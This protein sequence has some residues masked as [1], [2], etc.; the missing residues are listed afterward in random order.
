MID[1]APAGVRAPRPRRR[2]AARP[3]RAPG[4]SSTGVGT[5]MMTASAA[6]IAAMSL[7]S[8]SEPSARA[9]AS[10]GWSVSARS[11]CWAA[12]VSQP[13]LR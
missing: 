6:V 3:D 9:A 12:M 2:R 13:L 10:F 8:S 4:S 7:V 1:L 5:Q 11:A